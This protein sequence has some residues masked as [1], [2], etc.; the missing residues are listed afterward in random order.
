MLKSILFTSTL[1]VGASAFAQSNHEDATMS[2]DD[3]YAATKLAMSDYTAAT[4]DDAAN[5]YAFQ[6]AI[7]GNDA[8]V[9]LFVKHGTTTVQINYTCHK[10][11]GQLEC[12]H[13]G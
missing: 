5:L 9:K 2:I 4:P 3:V 11:D 13:H 6:G 7:A 8:N 12:H 10:H 1:L